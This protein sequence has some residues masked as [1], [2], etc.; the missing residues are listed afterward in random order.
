MRRDREAN[1]AMGGMNVHQALLQK[2]GAPG[3]RQFTLDHIYK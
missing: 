1:F 3:S 2:P